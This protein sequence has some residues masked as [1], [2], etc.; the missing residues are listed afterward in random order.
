MT[1]QTLNIKLTSAI[2]SYIKK[3]DFIAS[4]NLYKS[5]KFNCTYNNGD[6]KIKIKGKEYVQY[7]D[8]GNFLNKFMDEKKTLELIQM[9]LVNNL[10]LDL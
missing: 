8:E 1:I 4:G 5:I 9:F 10:T 6:L 2:K 7:L 3:K